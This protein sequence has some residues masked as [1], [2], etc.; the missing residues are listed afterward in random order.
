MVVRGTQGCV[1]V[2]DLGQAAG[3]CKDVAEAQP[4]VNVSSRG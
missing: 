2:G 4:G 3:E 1:L